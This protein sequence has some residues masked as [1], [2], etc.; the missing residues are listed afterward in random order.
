MVFVRKFLKCR[1]FGVLAVLVLANT[2]AGFKAIAE[3]A[4]PCYDVEVLF[5]RGVAER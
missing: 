4:Q 5:A 2:T 3:E 1:I